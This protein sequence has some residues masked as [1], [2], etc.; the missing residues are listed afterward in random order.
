MTRVGIDSLILEE[1]HMRPF[2]ALVSIVTVCVALPVSAVEVADY[3][4]A[5]TLSS[6]IP[7]APDLGFLGGGGFVD[8]TVDGT[9][10]RGWGFPAQTGLDLDVTGLVGSSV[11]SVVM[12]FEAQQVVSYAKLLDTQDRGPDTGLYY[13]GNDLVFYGGAGGSSDGIAAGAYYQVVVTRDAAGL[14]VG[15]VDGVQQFSF[16]DSSSYAV[17]S[18]ANRLVFFRDDTSTGDSENTAGT[19]VRIRLFDHAMGPSEVA[20]LDRLPAL[21]G[22]NIPTLDRTGILTLI[23]I[24]AVVALAILRRQA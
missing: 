11:Y 6:S 9:P 5:D 14:Y 22:V 23:A 18:P 24:M 7:G 1:E 16:T 2:A 13:V 4:F 17:I 21:A 10:V 20:A 3:Q 19:V 12:L 8:T 15:Y